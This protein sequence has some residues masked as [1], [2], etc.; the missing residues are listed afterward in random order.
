MARGVDL[1][2][3]VTAAFS[4]ELGSPSEGFFIRRT[5]NTVRAL[6]DGRV[7]CLDA[8]LPFVKG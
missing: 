1:F 3:I 4:G 8:V 2:K 7:R 5:K 6:I